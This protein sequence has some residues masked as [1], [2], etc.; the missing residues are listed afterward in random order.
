M[1]S[2]TS[3]RHAGSGGTGPAELVARTHLRADAF[4]TSGPDLARLVLGLM[5]TATVKTVTIGALRTP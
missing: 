1:R 3:R 5:Q 4:V 2:D